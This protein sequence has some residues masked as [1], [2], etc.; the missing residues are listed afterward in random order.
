MVDFSKAKDALKSDKAEQISDQGLDKIS[1]FAKSKLGE[2]KH[3][4][5]DSTRENLDKKIGN[6]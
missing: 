6:E 5:I 2:D 4:K 3:V 1:D